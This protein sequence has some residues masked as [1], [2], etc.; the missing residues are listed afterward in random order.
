M[1]GGIPDTDEPWMLQTYKDDGK[2][3]VSAFQ[4][5]LAIMNGMALHK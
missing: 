2:E 4:R 3:F 5:I 1:S